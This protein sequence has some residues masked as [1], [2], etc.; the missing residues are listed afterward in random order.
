MT[1]N[2]RSFK[3]RQLYIV[4]K[5]VELQGQTALSCDKMS[6]ALQIKRPASN[7]MDG[8]SK[9]KKLSKTEGASQTKRLHF[10]TKLTLDP[11]PDALSS[12]IEAR[13]PLYDTIWRALQTTI[14]AWDITGA[15]LNDTVDGTFQDKVSA[16]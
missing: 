8:A 13:S 10:L 1:Q 12:D 6:E 9:K 11:K 14:S 5:W 4:T 16:K 15:P 7:K 3:D 2:G